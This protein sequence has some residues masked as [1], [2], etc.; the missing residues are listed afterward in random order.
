[1]KEKIGVTVYSENEC[2]G[3]QWEEIKGMEVE[4]EVERS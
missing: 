4:L 2:E 3:N 1:M